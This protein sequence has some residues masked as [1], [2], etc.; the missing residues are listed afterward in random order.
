MFGAWKEGQ[1]LLFFFNWT[2][3]YLI[4]MAHRALHVQ[5]D[6][7]GPSVLWHVNHSF[8]G[9]SYGIEA[10]RCKQRGKGGKLSLRGLYL[11]CAENSVRSNLGDSLQ[12]MEDLQRFFLSG[13]FLYVLW[14]WL[15]YNLIDR[16]GYEIRGREVSILTSASRGIG[17]VAKVKTLQ[18]SGPCFCWD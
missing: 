11:M 14:A 13:N 16:A 8:S 10:C 12:S 15:I 1:L 18:S 9:V 17:W 5:I 7:I 6:W 3:L 2:H 4:C